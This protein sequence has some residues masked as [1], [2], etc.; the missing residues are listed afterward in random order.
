MSERQAPA[1]NEVW[2]AGAAEPRII[3]PPS[4]VVVS[5]GWT[6]PSDAGKSTGRKFVRPSTDRA[7]C[8]PIDTPTNRP[9]VRPTTSSSPLLSRSRPSSLSVARTRFRP[10]IGRFGRVS[11]SI[12]RSARGGCRLHA[13]AARCHIKSLHHEK[14]A[15][16]EIITELICLPLVKISPALLKKF[17]PL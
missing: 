4:S 5:L 3:T 2:R 10:S 15:R 7:P 1:D 13:G 12:R 6:T 17:S 11:I 16:R 8:R 9:R 14:S